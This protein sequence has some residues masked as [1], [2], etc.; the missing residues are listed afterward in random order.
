M[1]RIVKLLPKNYKKL[2]EITMELL[3]ENENLAQENKN[4]GE[5]LKQLGYTLDEITEI[6]YGD[7]LILKKGKE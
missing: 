1:D 7:F 5:F 6:A 3:E 4:F 2:R